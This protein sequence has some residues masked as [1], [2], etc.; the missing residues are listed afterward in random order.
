MKNTDIEKLITETKA[1]NSALKQLTLTEYSQLKIDTTICHDMNLFHIVS[2]V[3][4]MVNEYMGESM[5]PYTGKVQ[6]DN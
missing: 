4:A 5:L 1:H 6:H 3:D 2:V